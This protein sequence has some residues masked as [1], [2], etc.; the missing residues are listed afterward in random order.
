MKVLYLHLGYMEKEHPLRII[1]CVVDGIIFSG[2]DAVGRDRVWLT[3]W[4]LKTGERRDVAFSGHTRPV[5]A[6]CAGPQPG[7]VLSGGDVPEDA[8]TPNR[9]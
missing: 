6:L 1:T 5:Y 8:P 3:S 4:D 2:A 7:T 9:T